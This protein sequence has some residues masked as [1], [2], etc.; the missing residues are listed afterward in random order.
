V[1]HAIDSTAGADL[2]R[3]VTG[4]VLAGAAPFVVFTASHM[5]SLVVIEPSNTRRQTTRLATEVP[6]STMAFVAAGTSTATSVEQPHTKA[7]EAKES[8]D[9]LD[10]V[11]YVKAVAADGEKVTGNLVA[12]FLGVSAR[13]GRRRLDALKASH[14]NLLESSSLEASIA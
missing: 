12:E 14:P 5:L 9:E 2:R 3:I 11:E 1:M 4:A 6:A 8:N 13:T 10:L 7:I